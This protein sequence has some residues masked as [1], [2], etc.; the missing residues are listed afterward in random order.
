MSDTKV[1]GPAEAERAAF[2]AD[3]IEI[4]TLTAR[5]GVT[6]DTGDG[7]AYGATYTADGEMWLDGERL[8]QGT[9]ELAELAATPRGFVHVTS[10]PIIEVDGDTATQQCT[11]LLYRMS[12]DKSTVTLFGVGR[13]EDHLV[14]TGEGWRFASRHGTLHTSAPS[15]PTS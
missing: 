8:C 2:I 4:R 13:Y 12:R 10:D 9:A 7:P 14:R 15:T 11:L 1:E 5:S 3:W 6:F